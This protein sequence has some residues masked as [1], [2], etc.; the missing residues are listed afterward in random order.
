MCVQFLLDSRSFLRAGQ[1]LIFV[2]RYL[3]QGKRQA[4]GLLFRASQP[5]A[6]A[7]AVVSIILGCRSGAETAAD[8]LFHCAFC[9]AARRLSGG[10]GAGLGSRVGAR[11]GPGRHAAPFLRPG[12]PGK[13]RGS[14]SGRSIMLSVLVLWTRML[15]PKL[16]VSRVGVRYVRAYVLINILCDVSTCGR[17]W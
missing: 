5:P 10:L 2:W 9:C 15:A 14:L 16:S 8:A 4:R 7:A 13:R 1:T 12:R 11:A 6:A 17:K 3:R